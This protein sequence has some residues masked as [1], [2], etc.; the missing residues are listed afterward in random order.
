MITRTVRT[1]DLT[2]LVL[3]AAALGVAALGSV[4]AAWFG[5]GPAGTGV[6]ALALALV[7]LR[8]VWQDLAD[9]TIPDAATLAFGLLGLTSRLGDGGVSGD[10]V[11]TTLALVL[12]DAALGGGVLLALR[13]AYYRRRGQDGIGLGDVKL[14]AAGG[15]LV[16]TAGLAWAI[17]AASLFG[18]AVVFVVRVWPAAARTIAISDR[19]AFGAVLTPALWLT[20]FVARAAPFGAI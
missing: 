17:L 13:E 1:D 12:L 10:P 2:G 14:A 11:A 4:T 5:P 18:L 15:A 19:I 20:W 16:G 9:F 3:G 7:G 8:I 6:M